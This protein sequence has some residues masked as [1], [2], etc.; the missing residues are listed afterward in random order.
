ML[1]QSCG[2][3]RALDK[4]TPSI[5]NRSEPFINAQSKMLNTNNQYPTWIILLDMLLR[6]PF[7]MYI[8]CAI[9]M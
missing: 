1:W 9:F 3:T 8:L 6:L 4:E 2:E 5:L 7:A